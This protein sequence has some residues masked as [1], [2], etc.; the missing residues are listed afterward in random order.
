MKTARSFVVLLA[1][2]LLTAC[3][4]S[5]AATP[6]PT[7]PAT[8]TLTA[9]ASP[10]STESAT[11]IPTASAT[12][13][14]SPEPPSKPGPVLIGPPVKV[15]NITYFWPLSI[16]GFELRRENS[17]ADADGFILSFE[18]AQGL[19]ISL[20]ILGGTHAERDEYC[21]G[22]PANPATPVTVRGLEGCFPAATGAGFIVEWIENGTRYSVGGMGVSQE[23][24]L[25]T[26][27]NLEALDLAGFLARLAP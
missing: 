7:A 15:G 6:T 2:C 19:G 12:L 16:D 18:D 3:S 11:P 8:L 26:A 13:A 23:L 1:G 25:A 10:T 22:Q 4:A 24:A 21:Q 20:R 9:P 27:N 14:P 5:Q 17:Q